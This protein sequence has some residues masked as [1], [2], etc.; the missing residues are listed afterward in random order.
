METTMI[1]KHLKTPAMLL[2]LTLAGFGTAAMAGPAP[3]SSGGQLTLDLAD[4]G[5]VTYDKVK[6]VL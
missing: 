1:A 3:G 2:G 6:A 4:G 5:T